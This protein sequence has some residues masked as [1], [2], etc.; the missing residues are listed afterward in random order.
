[1]R[2]IS[3]RHFSYYLVTSDMPRQMFPTVQVLGR[4]LNLWHVV[5]YLIIQKKNHNQME[6]KN[7]FIQLKVTGWFWEEQVLEVSRPVYIW[8]NTCQLMINILTK[9][10]YEMQTQRFHVTITYPTN[11]TSAIGVI[12]RLSCVDATWAARVRGHISQVGWSKSCY[13]RTLPKETANC[14]FILS[15]FPWLPLKMQTFNLL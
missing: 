6:N 12:T 7:N 13:K 5:N 4:I 8:G 10:V 1:M 9:K 15:Y 11:G 3:G 2:N 14:L